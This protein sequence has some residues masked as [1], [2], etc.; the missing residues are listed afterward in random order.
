MKKKLLSLVMAVAMI[1][2]LAAPAF[3]ANYYTW[4]SDTSKQDKNEQTV[5]FPAKM[6]VPTVRLTLPNLSTTDA[7][8][9]NPYRIEYVSTNS[10]TNYLNTVSASTNAVASANYNEQ[11]ICPIYAIKN[12]TNAKMNVKARAETSVSGNLALVDANTQ[13]VALNETG[14]KAMINF[15]VK[16]Q[17]VDSAAYAGYKISVG[18]AMTPL[19]AYDTANNTVIKLAATN[20]EQKVATMSNAALETGGKVNYLLFQFDGELSRAPSTPWTAGDKFT[21]T[22][23]FTFSP[24]AIGDA[25]GTWT[26]S[27]DVALPDSGISQPLT[28]TLPLSQNGVLDKKDVA[29]FDKNPGLSGWVASVNDTAG[30]SIVDAGSL[31]VTLDNGKLTVPVTSLKTLPKDGQSHD[32]TCVLGFNDKNNVPRTLDLTLKI[33]RTAPG[34]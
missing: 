8:V 26:A 24:I 11:V 19:D 23:V 28:V 12:E 15:I 6:F 13:H 18:S 9:L 1:L 34:S 30:W 33:K 29:D 7:L 14:T 25:V 4:S 20:P 5:K 22:V 10:A 17:S 16:K 31:G 27:N 3:A 2:S 32:Y 21:T